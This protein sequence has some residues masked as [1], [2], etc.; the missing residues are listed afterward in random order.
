MFVHGDQ[1]RKD[2]IYYQMM[3]ND[4]KTKAKKNLLVLVLWDHWQS[5]LRFLDYIEIVFLSTYGQK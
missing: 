3:S 2:E 5:G 4:G 1:K